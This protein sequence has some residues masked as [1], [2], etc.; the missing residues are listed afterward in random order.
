MK[1]SSTRELFN[2]WNA[3]RGSRP[4]PERGEIEPSAIR[5]AL[6]DTFM[7]DIDPRRGHPF[8][9]AGTRVCALFGRELKGLSFVGLW[10][11][12]GRDEL[13]DLLASVVSETVGVV[14]GVSAASSGGAALD[15]ELLLLPLAQRGGA[16]SRLLGALAPTEPPAWLGAETLRPLALG[17][18]R[19][20][21]PQ[22]GPYS[23]P[24]SRPLVPRKAR[25]RHGLIVYDGGHA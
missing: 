4:A 1:H 20:L 6:A 15:L 8:R 22:T 2:Y 14:A 18:T 10:A 13:C 11:A 17:M 23:G 12:Q 16:S 5:R 24:Q 21:G 9:I 25:I 3:Q 19:Y 7:L